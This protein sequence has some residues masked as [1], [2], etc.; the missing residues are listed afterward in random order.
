TDFPAPRKIELVRL[1]HAYTELHAE[2][3][4]SDLGHTMSEGGRAAHP[5][6]CLVCGQVLDAN[7]RGEC[8]MHAKS[9][10][11]GVGIFFLLQECTVL[12][13]HGKMAAYFASPYVD[14]YGERHRSARGRPLFL[15]E[16]RYALVRGLWV[17]HLVAH[18]VGKKKKT[19]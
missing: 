11:C 7:G 6:V 13:I 2:I 16:R 18:E 19:R 3:S 17:K 4:S 14:A 12:L 5:V 1:P 10:G 15:D 9:C 8:T